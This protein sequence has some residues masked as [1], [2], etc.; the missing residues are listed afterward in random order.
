VKRRF[1]RVSVK[2]GVPGRFHVVLTVENYR[3]DVDNIL[4]SC[5]QSLCE[6]FNAEVAI[7]EVCQE[8]MH[9]RTQVRMQSISTFIIH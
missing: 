1:S 2:G 3:N 5:R 4:E 6:K 7:G 9:V 8:T